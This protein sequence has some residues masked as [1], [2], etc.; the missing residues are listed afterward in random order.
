[1]GRIG[2]LVGRNAREAELACE[3]SEGGG[4]NLGVSEKT[5]GIAKEVE[6]GK[7]MV[8]KSLLLDTGQ[9]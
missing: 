6:E 9:G 4:G 2:D 3:D 7:E 1:M 5:D 8:D